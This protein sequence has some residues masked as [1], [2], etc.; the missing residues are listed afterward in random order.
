MG[1]AYYHSISSSKV[2]G[3]HPDDYLF[4][5]SW[6]DQFKAHV[7]D[8][9]HRLF[10]H[11]SEGVFEAERVHGVVFNNSDNIVV[12]VRG[13]IEQH[14]VED[15]GGRIPTIADWLRCLKPEPWMAQNVKTTHGVRVNKL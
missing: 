15:C 5:H 6:M 12:P 10:L 7:G 4:L 14:I 11:N 3:G 2:F 8:F 9:R 13:V 1:H